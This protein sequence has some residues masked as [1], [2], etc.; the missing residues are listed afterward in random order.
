MVPLRTGLSFGTHPRDDSHT[1]ARPGV[2]HEHGGVQPDLPYYG[3][4]VKVE[5]AHCSFTELGAYILDDFSFN[6]NGVYLHEA[7]RSIG[8]RRGFK[9]ATALVSYDAQ[10]VEAFALQTD[11]VIHGTEAL[12]GGVAGH[13]NAHRRYRTVRR[14]PWTLVPRGRVFYGDRRCNALIRR[15]RRYIFIG[16][17][18]L[19]GG[20]APLT[21]DTVRSSNPWRYLTGVS[22]RDD[23]YTPEATVAP[24]VSSQR[25]SAVTF[26]VISDGVSVYFTNI[27]V[28]HDGGEDV[29]VELCLF[30]AHSGESK[31]ALSCR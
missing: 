13:G 19:T 4:H 27:P 25:P 1:C 18:L 17:G 24:S 26:Q 6:L 3:S 15:R 2:A 21:G 16:I 30:G 9:I 29:E 11:I 8:F 20:T 23:L 28:S 10:L 22:A 7:G 14:W 31:K 12:T 5:I